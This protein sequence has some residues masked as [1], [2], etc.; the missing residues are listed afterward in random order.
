MTAGFIANRKT[1]DINPRE[2]RLSVN[3]AAVEYEQAVS[4]I[5]AANDPE[6]SAFIQTVA[7]DLH[8]LP[9]LRRSVDEANLTQ[10]SIIATYTST[11]NRL[12]ELGPMIGTRNSDV[13]AVAQVRSLNAL[14][15]V[16][17]NTSRVR[18]ELNSALTTGTFLLGEF[19]NYVGAVAR[20]QESVDDFL[21]SAGEAQQVTYADTVK[22]ESVSST[23]AIQDRVSEQSDISR[24]DVD[25]ATWN[26]V[27]THKIELMREVENQLLEDLIVLSNRAQESRQSTALWGTVGLLAV[28]LA[29]AW[30]VIAV[31]RSMAHPLRT[32]RVSALEVA[33]QYLPQALARLR[34]ADLD[35]LRAFGAKPIEVKSKDEFGDV[36]EAFDA[37]QNAA[38]TLV[39]DQIALRKY[40]NSS[41]IHLSR[42]NQNLV[43]KLLAEIGDL[44]RDEGD[45]DRL[46]R[47]FR[48][49]HLATQM[50]RT[51]ESL[52]VL[53]GSDTG[54]MWPKPM[55]LADILL[56]AS[57]EV[58]QY[59]R[60]DC[61]PMSDTAIV[62]GVVTDL[63]HLLAE[64]M[65]NATVFSST[66]SRVTV[67]C[68]WTTTR[69]DLVVNIHDEGSG[70]LAEQLAA[71]NHRLATT[72]SLDPAGGGGMGLL[73]VGRLAAKHGI[74]VRLIH[75]S[76]RGTAALVRIPRELISLQN[77]NETYGPKTLDTRLANQRTLNGTAAA[78]PE[79]SRSLLPGTV[80]P[81][82]SEGGRPI[83]ESAQEWLAHRRFTDGLHL[84]STH[85]LSDRDQSTT[86]TS[87]GGESPATGG[88]S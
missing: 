78:P 40:I 65:E 56:A 71:L 80:D 23:Q 43:S 46:A 52:L 88:S 9:A 21:G 29:T 1:L 45:P 22:G 24:F 4:G 6:L 48:L 36:A 42:R 26:K 44:E 11:I 34:Q 79:S 74:N 85:A 67:T 37:I 3:S 15:R 60:I 77:F 16:V 39:R 61:R 57:A 68:E 10:S 70:I 51:D 76:R 17:E 59:T 27:S 5:D 58:E 73:V 47:L 32:L 8:N 62:A 19:S 2:Q 20:Q 14:I 13:E 38:A 50:L 12:M 75:S 53:A 28:F 18:A 25:P 31:V 41:F 72:S 64:L 82:S 86:S 49:D 66:R 54:R 84:D 33:N 7:A 30:L 55:P 63:V 81:I 87:E 83:F 69:N 35:D